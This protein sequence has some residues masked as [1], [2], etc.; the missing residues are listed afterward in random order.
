M[1][2]CVCVCVCVVPGACECVCL[3]EY[4]C[5][6]GRAVESQRTCGMKLVHAYIIQLLYIVSGSLM[7]P[8]SHFFVDEKFSDKKEAGPSY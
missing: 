1:R 6:C 4:R 7:P 8:G 5:V 2:V 3:R